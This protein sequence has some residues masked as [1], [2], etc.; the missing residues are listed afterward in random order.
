[1]KTMK[2]AWKPFAVCCAVVAAAA[3]ASA[4]DNTVSNEFWNCTAYTN[5]VSSCTTGTCTTAALDTRAATMNIS[6]VL[7]VFDPDRRTGA[8]IVFE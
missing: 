5:A 3:A 4:L 1:M 8:V 7:P 2:K 6:D